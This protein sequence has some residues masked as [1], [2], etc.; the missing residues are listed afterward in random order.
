MRECDEYTIYDDDAEDEDSIPAEP[1]MVVDVSDDIGVLS[2]E[3]EK[4]EAV[5]LVGELFSMPEEM[6]T[7][8]SIVKQLLNH[9]I[10]HTL[11]LSNIKGILEYAME[12]ELI[13]FEND[14]YVRID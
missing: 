10:Y 7:L 9:P 2:F 8:D 11:T 13:K 12:R 1:F 6:R 14:Y 5:H 3:M 4:S